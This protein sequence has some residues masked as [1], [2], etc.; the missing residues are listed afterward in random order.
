MYVHLQLLLQ[1][2]QRHVQE[3][4]ITNSSSDRSIISKVDKMWGKEHTR[5]FESGPI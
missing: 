4:V 1:K 3:P 2:T 5:Q